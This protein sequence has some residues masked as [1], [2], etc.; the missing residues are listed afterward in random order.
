VHYPDDNIMGLNFAQ[1][2]LGQALPKYLK[3]RY[4]ADPR[5]VKRKIRE[6]KYDWNTFDPEDPCPFLRG[7]YDVCYEEYW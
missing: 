7:S 1:E 2:I 5:A 6:M 4:N 3:E